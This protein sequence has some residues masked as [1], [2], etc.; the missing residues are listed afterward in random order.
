MIFREDLAK[1]IMRG[2]KTATRRRLS[3]NPRSPWWKEKCAYKVGQVFTINPG[4]GVTNIGRARVTA[5]YK[6]RLFDMTETAAWKEGFDSLVAFRIA[7]RSINGGFFNEEVW[8]V[9][10]EPVEVEQ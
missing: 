5:V 3:D 1:A 8:A 9:E 4:R 7:W 10:F 2:K 6:Q